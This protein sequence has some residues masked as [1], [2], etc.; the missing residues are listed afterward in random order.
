MNLE[1][2]VCGLELAKRLK[3]LGVKQESYFYHYNGRLIH[4]E[5]DEKRVKDYNPIDMKWIYYSAFTCTE[6]GE[7]LPEQIRLDKNDISYTITNFWSDALYKNKRL[8]CCG[9]S[10]IN[11]IKSFYIW[12]DTEAN[13]RASMLIFLLEN[14]LMELK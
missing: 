9:Y 2:Q 10:H 11:S 13:C 8:F 4:F 1:K 7:M 12:D 3:E 5:Y 14:K 6:L